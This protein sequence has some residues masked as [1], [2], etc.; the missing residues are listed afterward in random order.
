M[1]IMIRSFSPK[2]ARRSRALPSVCL[3]I[4][5]VASALFASRA[6]AYSLSGKSWP[7][8]TNLIFQM[9]LGNPL[10]PLSDGNTS[11]NA[12]VAP[13]FDM[14]NQNMQRLQMSGVNSTAAAASG[15]RVNTVVFA[16]SDYGQSFGTGT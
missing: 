7:S 5:C 6:A 16:T 12:A 2:A 15:D 4:A 10:L 8:G 13:A 9:N 3:A 1:E 14:W 11:W